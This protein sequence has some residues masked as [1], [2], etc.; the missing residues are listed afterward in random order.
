LPRLRCSHHPV[1]RS[2]ASRKI[3]TRIEEQSAPAEAAA[4]TKSAPVAF[5]KKWLAPFFA[6]GPESK[7]AAHFRAGDFASA[8]KELARVLAD[9]PAKSPERNPLRFLQALALMNQ[10]SWQAAGDIF[11]DLWSAYP[12]LAPYHAYNA[13]RCRLRRGDSD[14][15]FTWLARVP[16]GSVPEAEA[17]MVKVDAFVAAKRWAEVDT[18]T[19]PFWIPFSQGPAPRR[20]HVPARRGLARA[21]AAAAGDRGGLP[22]GVGR[23]AHRELGHARQ[24]TV[25][26]PWPRRCPE[27]ES[28]ALTA[29]SIDELLSRGM[30]LFDANQNVQAEAT[31]STALATPVSTRQ[32]CANCAS[33]WHSR[34]GS[35]DNDSGRPRCS[36]KPSPTAARPATATC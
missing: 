20:G 3:P 29:R 7:A 18:E 23:V 9:L 6:S 35:N 10:S 32:P 21:R 1:S 19:T 36:I 15:A 17:V 30:I 33:T 22:Q 24:T 27:A 12:L 26:K 2:P 13:A 31:F 8:S 4:V 14:G 25:W 28:G 16:S 34:C 11:E 5:D